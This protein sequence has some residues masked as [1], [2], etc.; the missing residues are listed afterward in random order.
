MKLLRTAVSVLILLGPLWAQADNLGPDTGACSAAALPLQQRWDKITYQLAE[1][2]REAAY[3]DLIQQTSTASAALPQC[4]ALWIWDGIT[5]STY[6]GA[7]GGLG[8]LKSIRH[9]KRSLERAIAID[10]TVLSGAAHTSLGSLY[11]Q[12]PGWPISFGDKKLAEQHL[13]LAL[14]LAPDD[15][16]A[17]YF[18]GDY[19]FSRKQYPQAQLALH[20]ALA[21]AP[22]PERPV[23][24]QGRRVEIQRLLDKI[25]RK[26]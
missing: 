19:L 3:V 1:A 17:N 23:A 26:L 10:P 14:E 5:R 18:Y 15:I 11:Y 9:A 7:A 20:K 16:D 4:A 6:A 13:R 2:D 21:A 25:A 8:A 12:A 24:D 22:R